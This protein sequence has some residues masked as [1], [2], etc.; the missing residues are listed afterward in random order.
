MLVCGAV[1]HPGHRL[2]GA[3]GVAVDQAHRHARAAVVGRR[4]AAA[5]DRKR[6]LPAERP[7]RNRGAPALAAARRPDGAARAGAARI[8]DAG[9]GQ[10]A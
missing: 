3:G 9:K 4:G 8:L 2:P 7:V 5:G 6:D 1:H 10:A